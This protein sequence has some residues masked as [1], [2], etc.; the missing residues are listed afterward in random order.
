MDPLSAITAALVAGSSAVASGVATEAVKDTY[1][2]LKTV[3]ADT[4]KLASTQLLEKKPTSP[5]AQ[6]AV[7]EEIQDTPA[8]L[9]DQAVLK[10]TKALQDAMRQELPDHLTAWGTDIKELEAGGNIIAEC[11]QGGVRG[12]KWKA[13]GDVRISRV[14]ARGSSSRN[15]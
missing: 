6:E 14:T 8:I 13:K 11:I 2:G 15:P 5:A 3:L 1:K 7:K 4:Y 12:K 9:D 10:K